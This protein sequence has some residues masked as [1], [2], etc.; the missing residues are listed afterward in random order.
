MLRILPALGLFAAMSSMAVAE[1]TQFAAPEIDVIPLADGYSIV[2]RLIGL[3]DATVS[4]TLAIEK[5]GPSGSVMTRQSREVKLA[6]GKVFTIAETN[7]SAG[8]DSMVKITLKIFRD[9]LTVGS[10][11]VTIGPQ[12]E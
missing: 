2:G 1:P 11:I 8:Q 12:E 4:S 9:K 6:V 3:S 7:L 10:A 5:K